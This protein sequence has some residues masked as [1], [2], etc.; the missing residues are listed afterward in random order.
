ML[1]RFGACVVLVLGC[2]SSLTCAAAVPEREKLK[3]WF[4]A[5]VVEAYDKTGQRDAKSDAAARQMVAAFARMHSVD[6]SPTR[7][8]DDILLEQS[9]ITRKHKCADPMVLY[10]TVRSMEHWHRAPEAIAPYAAQCAEAMQ[11]SAYH[12]AYKCKS[13]LRAAQYKMKSKTDI[14]AS[15]RAARELLERATAHVDAIAADRDVPREIVLDVIEDIGEVSR[16]VTGSREHFAAKAFKTLD[17]RCKDRS[18]VLTA[19]ANFYRDYA[20]DARGRGFADQV[21][22]ENFELMA[23][24][25]EPAAMAAE[26]AWT[27]DNNNSFACRAMLGIELG[28]GEGRERME[29]WFKRAMAADPDSYDACMN[30]LQYLEPKWYGADVN[31][32]LAFG[33]ECLA[34]GNWDVGLPLVLI[35]AH[36]A[37]AR[38]TADGYQPRPSPAYF[39]DDPQAWA[40]V[41]QVYDEYL[42]RLPDSLYHRSRYAQIAAWAGQWAEADE[43]FKAMG[44]KISYGYFRTGTKYRAARAEVEQHVHAGKQ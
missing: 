4:Q 1:I 25:L 28:Q 5:N 19:M 9:A 24:R 11:T 6:R 22:E 15:I 26:E 17:A 8:E 21:N 2:C 43:Q 10:I 40:D 30:K 23:E 34:G 12:P 36:L 3:R 35:D 16:E 14:A 7:D 18:L 29:T 42:R 20:W 33:R 39:R 31:D 32:M 41:K 44:D 27:I 38:Y 13:L 37:A